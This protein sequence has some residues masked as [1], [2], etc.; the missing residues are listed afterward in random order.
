MMNDEFD[1]GHRRRET[2]TVTENRN[3]KLILADRG[4]FSN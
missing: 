3:R 1:P 4:L 2:V